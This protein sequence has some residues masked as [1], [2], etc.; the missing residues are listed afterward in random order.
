MSGRL[1]VSETTAVVAECLEIQVLVLNTKGQLLK[2]GLNG[3]NR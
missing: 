3:V 2:E 1:G